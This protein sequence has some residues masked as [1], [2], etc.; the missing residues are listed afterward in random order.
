M[1]K[2]YEYRM[3]DR[4]RRDA[5]KTDRTRDELGM[6]SVKIVVERGGTVGLSMVREQESKQHL[7]SGSWSATGCGEA[8]RPGA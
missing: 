8:R 7:Q 1:H 3:S 6:V 4:T 5:E 2:I